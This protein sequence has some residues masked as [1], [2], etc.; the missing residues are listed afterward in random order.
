MMCG[1]ARVYDGWF[2]SLMYGTR[3][4]YENGTD[5]TIAD[6]HTHI[7]DE[8]GPDMVLHVA[9]GPIN[10]AAVA[11]QEDSCVSLFVAPVGSYYDVLRTG[12]LTRYNDEEWTESVNKRE[13]IV[14]RPPWTATLIAP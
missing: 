1:A 6:V 12:T 8:Q 4:D 5:Y 14:T 9:T 3:L 2:M 7:E 11:V 13:A 10:L